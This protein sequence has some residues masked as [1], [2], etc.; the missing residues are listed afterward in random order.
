MFHHRPRPHRTERKTTKAF[1][2]LLRLLRLL[3]TAENV[4]LLKDVLEQQRA[5]RDAFRRA[6]SDE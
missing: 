3:S 5:V 1:G 2:A 4:S 6:E